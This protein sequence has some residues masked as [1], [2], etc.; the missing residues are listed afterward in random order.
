LNRYSKRFGILVFALVLLTVPHSFTAAQP[1]TSPNANLGQS[2]DEILTQAYKPN[3]PG[4]AVIVVK[5]GKVVFRKGYGMANLELGVPVQPDMVFRLGSITKQFTAVAILMLVEQ[6]KLSLDDDLTKFLPDYPTKGQKIT[7]THLLTHTS[8]VK[9]YTSLPEW[10]AMWRKDMPLNELIALFKDKPMDFAPGERYAYNNSAYVLLGA[11][12]EKASGQSY[13]DFV[14]KNIFAPLGMTHSFYDNTARV[15]PRRVNGYSKPK[16]EWLNAAY[17]S[18]TQPHAAGSLA[19]SVDDLALW[20][21]ALYT[22]KLVKQETLKRAW[23]SAKLNSGRLTGYGFGWSLNSYEGHPTIEHGG[24]INGFSTHAVRMPDDRVYVAVLTNKDTGG[25]GPGRI[26]FRI[27]ALASGKPFRDPTEITLTPEALDKYVGVYQFTDKAEASIRREGD[28][29]FITL[30]GGGK[31]EI[32]PSSETAFFVKESRN[33]L[34]FARNAAGAVT[35]FTAS[36]S[37]PIQEA[38]KIDKPLPAE[39]QAVTVDAAVLDSYVGE[40]QVGPNLMITITKEGN[41]LF[42]QVIGQPRIELHPESTTK[43]F[44][45]EAPIQIEF[46]TDAS[47]KASGLTLYQGGQQIQAK[48]IK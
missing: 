9:P 38:A 42:A 11:I 5:D 34:T 27:A 41:K 14:E 33:R 35:G 37:G 20:D 44:V 48:R 6:G 2:I 36:G 3:E 40:Y 12:I 32:T 30:P 21:A 25:P 22:D 45:K 17:L 13:A 39:K 19:S 26:T 16:D 43:F 29:L 23:T 46:V 24:G 1:A 47:G 4:A 28:K 10:L 15:F 8:G 7:I 31:T 18:M